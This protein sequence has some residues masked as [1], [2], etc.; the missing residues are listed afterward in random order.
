MR[1]SVLWL[2]YRHR[3]AAA[4]SQE[5]LAGAGIAIGVA[6]AFAV[7]VANGSI[8]SSSNEIVRGIVGNADLQ[9]MSRDSRG[10]DENT[11]AGVRA[12]PS[13]RRAGTLLDQRAVIVGPHGQTGVN[14]ASIDES[15]ARMSRFGGSFVANALGLLR[16]V[17]LTRA[18]SDAI[19]LDQAA[20]SDGTVTVEVRGLAASLPV[21][22]TLGTETIGP[23]ST[24][25]IAVMPLRSLQAFT[26]L[27]GRVTRILVQAHPGEVEQAKRELAPIARRLNLQLAPA[28]AETTLLKQALGPS[29]WTTGFF[30]AISA[31]LGF[32]LAFNAVLLTAPERRRGIV[33]LRIH[34]YRRRQLITI[35]TSQAILLGLAAS[36]VGVTVGALLA[37]RVFNASPGYLAPAFVPGDR[38]IITL[39][40]AVIATAG[41]ILACVA[42]S[43]PPLLDLRSS[44]P[45]DWA[46]VGSGEGTGQALTAKTR[47][48]LPLIALGAGAAAGGLL[49]VAPSAALAACALLAVSTVT[50]TPSVFGALLRLGGWVTAAGRMPTLT[51]AL[52]ALRATTLRSLALASTGALAVFGTVSII[53]ARADLLRGIGNYTADYVSTADLWV[54]NPTDNQATNGIALPGTESK[55]ARVPGVAAVRPYRG[56]FLDIAGRRVWIIARS[57]RD[58]AMLPASQMVDG[59]LQAATDAVRHGGS[60]V[61]G[62]KLADA[63]HVKVGGRLTLPTPTGPRVWKVAATTTNLGWT[64][65]AVIMRADDYTAAWGTSI[66]TALEADLER[67]ANVAA[68]QRAIAATLG[69]AAGLRV[70][71]AA[72]RANGI[73]ASAHQGLNQLRQISVLLLIGAVLA[74][75]TAMSAAIWQRRASLAGLRLHGYMPRQLWRLLLVETSVVLAAGCLT[76]T[77][78]GVLGQIGIDRYLTET[79]GF[80]VAMVPVSWQTVQTFSVVLIA[81]MLVVAIPGWRAS[82]A[83]ARLGLQE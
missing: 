37:S 81:A 34:G 1:P 23:L 49:L 11:I 30:A 26:G 19:G 31:M 52:M 72:E 55:V 69:P 39:W 9:L 47:R 8:A 27:R 5:L 82:R 42:A 50:A 28:T 77:L 71:T 54:V 2:H 66:P 17:L 60:V 58:R 51:V 41:G 74:M 80:P 24:A 57:T 68:T 33:H 65:G 78:V 6:L 45:I 59:D 20:P 3:L 63:L 53:G 36:I 14:L 21:A 16:G 12:L 10:F 64:P 18:A 56:G 13:V 25:P 67:G 83:P 35:L 40:P 70:Q 4:W 75:A 22:A 73:N 79:T 7:L 29:D 61:I 48:T 43:A 62:T 46:I 76:G 32:L 44:R 38:T 15:M